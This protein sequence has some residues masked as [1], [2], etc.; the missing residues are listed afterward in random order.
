MARSGSTLAANS[1]SRLLGAPDSWSG[2]S[3]DRIRLRSSR[4]YFFHNCFQ[5]CLQLETIW[6]CLLSIAITP[7]VDEFKDILSQNG[8]S[9]ILIINQYVRYIAALARQLYCR[10]LRRQRRLFGLRLHTSY[11]LV[12]AQLQ[13]GVRV[14][15]IVPAK[16]K[17]QGAGVDRFRG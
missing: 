7:K 6:K 12:K 11:C 14:T 8:D 3:R 1:G 9:H 16:G 10:G 2:G 17:L 5:G 15:G 13:Q 4:P